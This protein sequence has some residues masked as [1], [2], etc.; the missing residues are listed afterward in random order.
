MTKENSNKLDGYETLVR[1]DSKG[2]Q[3]LSVHVKGVKCAGCIQK[4][5]SKA[6]SY[7]QVKNAR[8]NFSSGR[9]VVSWQG[10]TDFANQIAN[11]IEGLG[12]QVSPFDQKSEEDDQKESRFLLMCIGVAGFAMGNIMLLS[13]G[14]WIT[15]A[16]TM[17]FATREFLHWISALIGIPAIIF[18]GRPFFRSAWSVL[19]NGHTNMDVPISLALILATGMS[20]FETI[21]GGE[22]AYFDSAV[23]LMFFLLIGRYLD[24]KV[25]RSAKGAA[26][27][28]LQ[29]LSGFATVVEGTKTRKVLI[30]DLRQDMI[31]Q[32]AAGEKIPVDGV[33]IEGQSSLDT[34]LV[35]GETLPA[36]VQKGADVYAGTINLSASLKIK[37]E[38]SAENSLLS[39]IVRLMEKAEQGQA[40][41]VRLADKAAR[42]YTPIVHA[43]ALSAFLLWWLVFGVA[44]QSAL[45][46]AVTVLIITCPCAL[47]LAVPVVQVLASSRLMKQNVLVKSGDALEKL[48]KIDTAIFDKTGT[49]TIGKP[50]LIGQYE[51]KQLQLAASL[52]SH[53][54]HPF[55][56]A[57]SQAYDGDL[58]DSIKDI[59]EHSG[60]G[61]EGTHQGKTIKLGNAGFCGIKE[62]K[63]S[64]HSQIFLSVEGGDTP[65]CFEFEDQLK[66]DAPAI[67][68]AL[69]EMG[70]ETHLL[71]GDRQA[72]A[73]KV[74]GEL[75]MNNYQAQ[76]S[77]V[78]K[79]D[80][81]QAL[82][83]SGRNILM[84]GDGLNDA[85][86]L[87]AAD[88]SMAPG[89]AI[90]MAQNAADII[91]M[92]DQ[93][94]PVLAT[95]KTAK[96]TQSLVKQNFALAVSYNIIAVPLA[97]AGLVTPMVAAIAMSGS[98][99]LVIANSFRVKL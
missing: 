42:L 26:G 61:L 44:W 20:L 74:A 88:V 24:H 78:D 94:A 28:L 9:L 35:T 3:E 15:D 18:S 96:K 60:D 12:Y 17:G 5:E 63:S 58:L 91:F 86:V 34:S 65:V 51:D 70:I 77:P 62:A 45:L 84:V 55:S 38:K 1:T 21:H 99:L 16:Q 29:T 11:D 87:S 39:D 50:V 72:V 90:D 14:L 56:Q 76:L 43:M 85:P 93:L 59:K 95:L 81:L 49:L 71:T 25:R 75:D 23:M 89:S 7:D 33:I 80:I 6:Y 36:D 66:Q 13:V 32:V 68:N 37:V 19:K 4:I 69:N 67:I 30:R 48:A 79:Y 53:S 52:A 22:H 10:N 46:I 41:Y 83:Q 64:E 8:L 27:E 31:V 82:K 57:L 54:Q 92:S 2:N 73:E 98:S 97:F 40:K 47:G